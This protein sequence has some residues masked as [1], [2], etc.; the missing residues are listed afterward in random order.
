L[1]NA[2]IAISTITLAITVVLVIIYL[3]FMWGSFEKAKKFLKFPVVALG[4]TVLLFGIGFA[5]NGFNTKKVEKPAEVDVITHKFSVLGKTEIDLQKDLQGK[6]TFD[7]FQKS[8][9]R[10]FSNIKPTTP[11]TQLLPTSSLNVAN[12]NVIVVAGNSYIILDFATQDN[13]IRPVID[14]FISKFAD[15]TQMDK[16]NS[17]LDSILSG[18]ISLSGVKAGKLYITPNLDTVDKTH[19]FSVYISDT[20]I[21]G[22]PY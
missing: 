21:Y 22:V 8:D 19:P 12:G 11:S 7:A 5:S 18:E 1:G 15:K 6:Y 20:P 17:H 16:I 3:V 10:T 2:L 13:S 9:A 4:I 14:E